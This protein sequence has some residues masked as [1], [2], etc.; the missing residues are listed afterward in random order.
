MTEPEFEP[1]RGMEPAAVTEPEPEQFA[2][3]VWTAED[4]QTLFE[5]TDEQAV[6]FLISNERH[7]RDR[8]CEL[9]WEVIGTFGD[10]ANLPRLKAG[11]T[12]VCRNVNCEFLGFGYDFAG[13][14]TNCKQ[15][16][17]KELDDG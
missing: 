17:C 16:L 3:L 15:R 9:G 14:C 1:D 7:I 4:V 8:L 5:V 13:H 12:Y 2:K 10:M 11:Y 6:E